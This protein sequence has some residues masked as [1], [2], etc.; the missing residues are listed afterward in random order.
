MKP[1]HIDINQAGDVWREQHGDP[2]MMS[3]RIGEEYEGRLHYSYVLVSRENALILHA[4]Q[5]LCS[6]VRAYNDFITPNDEAVKLG[7]NAL[8]KAEGRP[9]GTSWDVYIHRNANMGAKDGQ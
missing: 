2:T 3:V 6:A 9:I 8:D 1:L 7:M 5:D 4:A